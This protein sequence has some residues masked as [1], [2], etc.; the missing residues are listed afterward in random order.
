ML[1]VPQ[2]LTD[3][4]F[5]HR[6]TF[7]HIYMQKHLKIL[8]H[9]PIPYP[10]IPQCPNR[11]VVLTSETEYD[12]YNT[13]THN[14]ASSSTGSQCIYRDH[15]FGEKFGRKK[16]SWMPKEEGLSYIMDK[17][18]LMDVLIYVL[19]LMT[20]D[21]SCYCYSAIFRVFRSTFHIYRGWAFYTILHIKQAVITLHK[22][23]SIASALKYSEL[24]EWLQKW[25]RLH[26]QENVWRRKNIVLSTSLLPYQAASPSFQYF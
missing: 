13:P 15:I 20:K 8:Q 7:S 3:G 21:N 5:Q 2:Q 10:N 22:Q 26:I 24:W 9:N 18:I 4:I 17:N 11:P 14:P 12:C 19:Q 6:A 25:S 16:L 23:Y 1:N